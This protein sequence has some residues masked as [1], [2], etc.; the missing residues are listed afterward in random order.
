MKMKRGFTLIELLIVIAIIGILAAML[1]PALVK[2]KERA[3]RMACLSNA[4]Q[5]GL[6]LGMYLDDNTQVF[7]EFSI[8]NSTPGA[9]GGY[10]QDN[11]LWTDLAGFAANGYGNGAWFKPRPSPEIDN[12]WTV[13][14]AAAPSEASHD[15]RLD[16]KDWRGA[17]LAAHALLLARH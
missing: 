11:I 5:W 1:L 15:Q 14:C 2:A 13:F 4:R 7:P 8:A 17:L 9:R 6:A 12:E 3:N 10:D 16:A